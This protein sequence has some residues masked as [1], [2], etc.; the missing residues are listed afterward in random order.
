M[1]VENTSIVGI[2][3][4]NNLTQEEMG[5]KLGMAKSTYSQKEQG[6]IAWTLSDMIKLKKFFNVVIDDLKEVK[7]MME[8]K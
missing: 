2:R 3:K 4:W 7:D 5:K 8:I 1:G 6:A